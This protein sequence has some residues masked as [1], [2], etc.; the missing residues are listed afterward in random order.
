MIIEHKTIELYGK[1]IFS[2][3]TLTTPNE[4]D[5]PLP[6]DACVAYIS[7]GDGQSLFAQEAIAANPGNVIVSICGRTVGHMIAKQEEGRV[8]TMIAHFHTEQLQEIYRDSKPK[9][10]KELEKPITKFVVQDAATKLIVSYFEG[11]RQF[12]DHQ[13][14]IT[15]EI[16]SLK[17][18][19]LILL[20]LQ[21]ESSPE[22]R[23]IINS[24]FSD[25]VFTFRE[26]IDTY[27]SMPISIEG[28]AHLTN[29][30]LSSF[31]REFKRI[32]ATTPGAY[33]ITKRLEKVA[34]QLVTSDKSITNICYD[35][36]FASLAHLSRSFKGKYGMSPTA[37]RM[38]L[39]DK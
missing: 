29:K 15:E 3:V 39:S 4:I 34:E 35:C 17:I 13:M 2:W 31:K 19:E 23:C 11:I 24:L 22:I 7:D 8:S 20:L 33:I 38:N 9:L 6:S 16:L 37:Y 30:S 21:S 36:G 18:Q 1:P 5:V 28:L 10:W 14:A 32:Y 27:I 12:F 26:V 25:R